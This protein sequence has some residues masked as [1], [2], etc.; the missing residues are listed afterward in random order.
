MEGSQPRH[1]AFGGVA[2][3]VLKGSLSAGPLFSGFMLLSGLGILG[4]IFRAVDAP[5]VYFAVVQVTIVLALCRFALNGKAGEWEG[6]LVSSPGGS[7]LEAAKVG[8]R[9]GTLTLVWLLPVLLLGWRPQA[10]MASIG[11]LMMGDGVTKVL[12]LTAV[13]LTLTALTPPVFLIVSVGANRFSDI[14]NQRHWKRLF[15][16]R[17][18][19]LFLVYSVYLGALGMVLCLSLPLISFLAGRREL[20]AFV[21]FLFV[22]FAGG[23]SLD[24]LGR[25]CGFFAA[26]VE[27]LAKETDESDIIDEP[28]SDSPFLEPKSAP[29][30]RLIRSEPNVH[31]ETAAPASPVQPVLKVLSP[32]GKPPLLDA[33]ERLDELERRQRT[34]PEGTISTLNDMRESYA[35]HPLVLHRLAMTLAEQGNR[36]ESLAVAREAL[37]LCLERG[38]QRLAAEIYGAHIDQDFGLS[39]DTVLLLAQDLR[40][41]GSLAAAER[42]FGSILERDRGERRAVKGMLQVA[43][44]HLVQS[45]YTEAQRLFRSLLE[46]C[47][48][49]P[50]AMH[51]QD[52]LAEAERRLA[53]AS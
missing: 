40:R 3:R 4:Y 42:A 15:G 44:D 39:R 27:V 49:S 51:M 22:A 19:D 43:E 13:F 25:L 16:G 10:V 17:A 46:R 5:G 21:G 50:L 23:M 14:A 18:A 32:T 12:A 36:P 28:A 7:I 6:S 1:E 26:E 38:A 33:R 34:D 35:P 9:Y 30:L 53:K 47:G 45:E 52:G 29:T 11:S 37:P 2:G 8:A 31:R 41:H 24:L 20:A 48:D